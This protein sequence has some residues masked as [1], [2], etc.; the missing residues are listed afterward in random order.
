MIADHLLKYHKTRLYRYQWRIWREILEA[1][2]ENLL[3]FTGM[4]IT[5]EDV[6]ALRSIDL[7]YEY[8]R[9]SGKT[10]VIVHTAET[11]MIFLSRLFAMPIHIGIFA[12]QKEQAKTDFDRLKT[13]LSRTQKDLII[14]D[15]DEYRK[16]KEE[17][18][19]KTIV[20]GNGSSCYIFPVTPT[21]H[22]ESKT[23]H[24]I[25]LEEAQDL[26]D[27]IVNEQIMPMGAATNAPIIRVGTAGTQLCDYYWLIQKGD[28][29]VM[30]YPEIAKDRR[31]MFA[32]TSDAQHLIY[33]QRVKKDIEKYGITD[34]RIQRPYYNVWQLEAGMYIQGPQLFAGRVV[35][36]FDN[37]SADPIY[38][39]YRDWYKA[40]RRTLPE[41]DEYAKSHNIPPEKY[42]LYRTWSEEDHYFGLD[43]AKETDQTILK[44]GRMIAGKLTIIRSLQGMYG[45]NYQ[46]QFDI[47]I[48]EL[49]WFK[50]AA[51]SI[52]STGQGDFMP[53][54]FERG[55]PYKIYRVPFS[56][57][58]KDHMY[59]S[60]YQKQVNGEFA[61]Y[62]QDPMVPDSDPYTAKASSEFEDEFVKLTKNYIGEYMVVKHPDTKDGHDDHPD[63]TTLMNNAYDSYN[64]TSGLLGYYKDQQTGEAVKGA[65]APGQMRGKPIIGAPE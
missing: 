53:D 21:S 57:Q 16:A 38:R 55:S 18:N 12:P 5:E 11:I 22:P 47:I 32:A 39:A 65:F 36:P 15:H 4:D 29:Y 9:Q 56:R 7:S 62:Y 51:G 19:A 30:T 28:A 63:A 60:L 45:L 25:L 40:A 50:I 48:A 24:L 35:R 27:V 10:T 42:T 58:S 8:T 61:Y 17:S 64:V 52:D 43:T 54:L 33:E 46:D 13:A 37:P 59:T 6:A 49:Q 2:I 1:L 41:T 34:A 31:A 26:I 44:I 14:V 20:L 3:A 23:L